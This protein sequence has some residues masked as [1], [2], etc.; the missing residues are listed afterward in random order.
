[1]LVL[2]IHLVVMVAQILAVVVVVVVKCLLVEVQVD[3]A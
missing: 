2:R 1:V 3:L